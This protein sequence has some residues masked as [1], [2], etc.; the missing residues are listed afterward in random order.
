MNNLYRHNFSE[1]NGQINNNYILFPNVKFDTSIKK[2]FSNNFFIPPMVII[3]GALCVYVMLLGMF[4]LH[5][6]SDE[7]VI[8]EDERVRRHTI[9]ENER[10][11]K[12]EIEM[13]KVRCGK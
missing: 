11:R 9:Q 13:E 12:H 4:K 8:Q 10:V 1:K 2:I 7:R 6:L 5:E 3:A